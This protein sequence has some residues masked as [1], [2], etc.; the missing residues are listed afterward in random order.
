MKPL[1][2]LL[3]LFISVASA[4]AIPLYDGFEYDN[5]SN[6]NLI[7]R[8]DTRDSIQW[9]QA[10]PNAALTNQPSIATG[11]LNYPGRP[12]AKGNRVHM[13]GNSGT[14]ARFSLKNADVAV[15]GSLYYSFVLRISD[16]SSL[17]SSGIFWI[18]FNNTQGSQTTAPSVVCARFITK[19]DT[20]IPGNYF[21]GLSKNSGTAAQFSYTTNSFSTTDVLFVVVGYTFIGDKDT[22]ADD[23]CRMWVNPDPSTFGAALPPEATLT[24]NAGAD[25]GNIRS[26]VL[27]NRS[28]ASPAS[29]TPQADL[30]ELLVG[31]Q[32]SDMAPR[33]NDMLALAPKSQQAISGNNVYLD[34]RAQM[35][36]SWKWQFNGTDIPGATGQSL[37][38]TN[39]QAATAGTYSVVYSNAAGIFT[40][41]A[42]VSLAGGPHLTLSPLWSLAPNARPYLT[43]DAAGVTDQRS[44]AY[45]APSN[46]VYIASMTNTITGASTGQVYVV[47]GTTGADIYQLNSD[48]SVINAPVQNSGNRALNCLDVSDDGALYG[49]NLT[50]D[51]QTSASP[52]RS[53]RMYRWP[54]LGSTTPPI[55]VYDALQPAVE[56][57]QQRWGDTF[58]VRGGGIGTQVAF[59]SDTGMYGLVLAPTDGTLTSFISQDNSFGFFFREPRPSQGRSLQFTATNSLWQKARSVQAGGSGPL[60]KW[61]FDT[62]SIHTLAVLETNA[63]MFSSDLGPVAVDLSRNLMAGLSFSPISGTADAVALY[64]ISNL[65]NPILLGRYNF[66]V[67]HQSNGNSFGRVIIS[68]DRIYAINANNGVLAVAMVPTL[69]ITPSG[70][71][72]TLTWPTNA[73]GYT[74]QA[75]PSL[76]APITWTNV[77]IGSVSGTLNTLTQS[78]SD[79]ASFYRL[80]K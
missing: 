41:N 57:T 8:I 54:D 40:S 72:V 14:A 28:V 23:Y 3:T 16:I 63:N 67:V 75:T 61:T 36:D 73:V 29:F 56:Q 39:L 35:A 44:L 52:L 13:G 62:N 5:S 66:P 37:P 17:S 50:D 80:K 30:D 18:G 12:P 76:T 65:A 25:F 21:I 68:G 22:S 79:A 74:L 45:Y 64:D 58:T 71:N 43:V 51:A 32:W 78:A 46:Q 10:G 7:G 20:S 19:L 38:V 11:S 31:T 34:T 26:L 60:Q 6:T 77:G 1:V 24:N 2:P 53:L 59:D 55:K 4:T 9:F 47:D 42:V 15:T 48:S 49:A 27:F 69:D 70:G 33:T